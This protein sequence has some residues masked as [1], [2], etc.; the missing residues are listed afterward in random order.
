[1]N[2]HAHFL[3]C[4]PG[5]TRQPS[6]C[7]S[8]AKQTLCAYILIIHRRNSDKKYGN[9]TYTRN[10]HTTE[11]APINIHL[12]TICKVMAH[13]SLS[14]SFDDWLFGL[15]VWFSLRVREVLGSIPRTA[16]TYLNDHCYVMSYKGLFWE[17]NPGPLAPEARIMP[18]DQTA[19]E[20][21]KFKY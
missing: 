9:T 16:L 10:T 14:F 21:F 11:S 8:H 4:Q 1:M 3:I 7:I 12:K 18:L 15:V 19:N 13:A 17:L 6:Q 20:F 2:C 5:V